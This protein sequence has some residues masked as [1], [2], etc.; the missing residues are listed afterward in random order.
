LYLTPVLWRSSRRYSLFWQSNNFKQG[1]EAVPRGL[2]VKNYL[3][4]ESS[5]VRTCLTFLSKRVSVNRLSSSAL[6]PSWGSVPG[7]SCSSP[8]YLKL[9][10]IV[11]KRAREKCGYVCEVL[12]RL[13]VPRSED[14]KGKA[15]DRTRQSSWVGFLVKSDFCQPSLFRGII[16]LS[17]IEI[18][19]ATLS[20]ATN[21]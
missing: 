16:P 13:M 14:Q 9:S 5:N 7:P 11:S 19:L 8:H 15:S 2:W 17:S 21:R 1:W 12:N 10:S 20:K 6:F 3:S 4:R 18:L